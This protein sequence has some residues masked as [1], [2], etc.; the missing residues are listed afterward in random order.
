MMTMYN[1]SYMTHID[2]KLV[3]KMGVDTEMYAGRLSGTY[4]YGIAIEVVRASAN[5]G[6]PSLY[7]YKTATK[8]VGGGID[9]RTSRIYWYIAITKVAVA[10]TN[11]ELYVGINI[12]PL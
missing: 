12:K 10:C 1:Y 2:M 4:W 9:T 6:L 3:Q 11:T 7:W 8:V 5:I